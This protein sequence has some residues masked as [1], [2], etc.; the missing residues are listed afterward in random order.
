MLDIVVFYDRVCE[1]PFLQEE[2]SAP[3]SLSDERY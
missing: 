1:I 3:F 2:C